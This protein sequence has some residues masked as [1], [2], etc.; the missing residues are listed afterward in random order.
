VAEYGLPTH[1]PPGAD[2]GELVDLMA[3]DQKAVDGL[4]FV[5]DGPRRLEVV[6]GIE[7]TDV[8]ATLAAMQP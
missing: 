5:L 8:E 3:R 1:A 2:P 4:T 6:R 7:R